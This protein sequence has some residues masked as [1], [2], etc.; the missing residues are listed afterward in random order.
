M[1]GFFFI[2]NLTLSAIRMK[3]AVLVDQFK[4]DILTSTE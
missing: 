2:I 3:L 1:Q 4:R